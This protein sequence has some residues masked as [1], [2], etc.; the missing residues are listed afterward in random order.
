MRR[1]LPVSTGSGERYCVDGEC[2]R[3]VTPAGS[4]HVF[5]RQSGWQ[6]S[7]L[8]RLY[9]PL[10]FNGGIAMHGSLSVPPYPASHGCVRMPEQNAIAFFNAVEAGTP[11]HVFGRT[12]LQRDYFRYGPQPAQPR[13]QRQYRPR[14]ADPRFSEPVYDTRAWSLGDR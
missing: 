13:P 12:P 2:D 14:V 5:E 11:V 7:R 6:T 1:I 3:A 10:Y 8:G 4:F 9:N